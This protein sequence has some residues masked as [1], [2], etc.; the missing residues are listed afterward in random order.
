[1]TA[2]ILLNHQG[3]QTYSLVQRRAVGARSVDVGL[4][5]QQKLHHLNVVVV[6]SQ[7]ERRNTL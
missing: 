6:D 2:K 5:G 3:E 1:M 7:D 4:L